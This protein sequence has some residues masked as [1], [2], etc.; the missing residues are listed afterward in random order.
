MGEVRRADLWLGLPSEGAVV[1]LGRGREGGEG[2]GGEGNGGEREGEG[3]VTP[4]YMSTVAPLL[5]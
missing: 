4:T 2:K 1:H 3:E 5:A